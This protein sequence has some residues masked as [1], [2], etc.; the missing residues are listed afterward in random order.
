MIAG[1][2]VAIPW[3]NG[4]HSKCRIALRVLKAPAAPLPQVSGSGCQALCN[5]EHPI[6]NL[7]QPKLPIDL[8]SFAQTNGPGVTRPTTSH[9]TLN[10]ALNSRSSRTSLSE[11]ALWA[12]V[13]YSTGVITRVKAGVSEA[14]ATYVAD[15]GAVGAARENIIKI[16]SR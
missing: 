16:T 12:S 3:C 14:I 1:V 11:R 5:A 9:W 8:R 6:S 4:A 15:A 7:A 13:R 10:V 2:A